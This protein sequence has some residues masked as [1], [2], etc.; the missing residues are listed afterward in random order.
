M[1]TRQHKIPTTKTRWAHER[2]MIIEALRQRYEGETFGLDEDSS[3]PAM[4]DAAAAMAR[5]LGG[6]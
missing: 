2:Y 1:S 6:K 3:W 5:H 4:R